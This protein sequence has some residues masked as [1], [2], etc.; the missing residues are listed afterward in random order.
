MIY[1]LSVG[2]AFKLIHNLGPRV[3]QEVVNNRERAYQLPGPEVN[4]KSDG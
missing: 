2:S 4:I 1:L 3:Q